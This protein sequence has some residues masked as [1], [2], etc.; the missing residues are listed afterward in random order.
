[1]AKLKKDD[2]VIVIAG[3]DKG[4]V[5]A[6]LNVINGSRVVVEGANTVKK[7]QKPNPQKGEQGG[8]VEMEKSLHISNVAIFNPQTE[9]ADRVRYLVKEDG[10]KVRVFASNNDVIDL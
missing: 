3:K 7:H 8:V 9:K 6:V 2:K 4:K 10:T 5:G 1:M